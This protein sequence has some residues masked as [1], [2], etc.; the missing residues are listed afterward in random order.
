MALLKHRISG[1]IYIN[2]TI[3]EFNDIY[4]SDSLSHVDDRKGIANP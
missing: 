3:Y 2:T 1:S 4:E